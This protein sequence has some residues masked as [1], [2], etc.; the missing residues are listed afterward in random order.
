MSSYKHDNCE[1][2]DTKDCPYR[3][4]DA[5]SKLI[6][7]WIP[8]NAPNMNIINIEA[9]EQICADCTVF[10]PLSSN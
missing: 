8:G 3:T 9:V 5:M 1:Y 7:N 4:K 6:G 10:E 2:Y